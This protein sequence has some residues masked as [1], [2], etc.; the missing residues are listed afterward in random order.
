MG[1]VQ[2]DVLAFVFRI[3][4]DPVLRRIARKVKMVFPLYNEEIH[5][6]GSQGAS[7]TST[8]SRTAAWR[9]VAKEA[10]PI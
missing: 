6:L 10:G 7:R 2:S 5:I 8:T 3:Q 9:S 1:I 4:N